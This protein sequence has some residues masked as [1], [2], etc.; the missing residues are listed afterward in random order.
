[1]EKN[2]RNVNAIA[3]KLGLVLTKVTNFRLEVA[4]EEK[5]KR[6]NMIKR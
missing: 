6:D 1:M 5:Q 3:H 2:I 4:K